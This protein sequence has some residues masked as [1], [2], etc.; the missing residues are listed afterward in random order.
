MKMK[1]IAFKDLYMPCLVVS[2][3]LFLIPLTFAQESS[4]PRYQVTVSSGN[5]AFFLE[6]IYLTKDGGAIGQIYPMQEFGAG[7]VRTYTIDA[8]AVPNDVHINYYFPVG[9]PLYI[10]EI[11]SNWAGV[12]LKLSKSYTMIT[13]TGTP[14]EEPPAT[15]PSGDT[16]VKVTSPAVGGIW[17]PVDKLGLLAPYIG[18]ASTIVVATVA[19]AIYA[20]RVKRRKKKQ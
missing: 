18:L 6:H 3:L 17:V 1:K 15:D 19:T 10:Y 14:L 2:I 9:G 11:P 8:T 13:G 7:Q 20:K 16:T 5:N 12:G 4:D